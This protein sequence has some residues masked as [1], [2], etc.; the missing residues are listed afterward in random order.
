MTNLVFSKVDVVDEDYRNDSYNYR[1]EYNKVDGIRVFYDDIGSAPGLATYKAIIDGNS[2]G[3]IQL[4][5]Y[6][7]RSGSSLGLENI[8]VKPEYRKLGYAK[9]MYEQAI[10]EFELELMS[11]SYHRVKKPSQIKYWNDIGFNHI[12]LIPGQMGSDK[13]LCNLMT[14]YSDTDTLGCFEL[15]FAGVKRCMGHSQRITK[16]IANKYGCYVTRE[17]FKYAGE[18]LHTVLSNH[19]RVAA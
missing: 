18:L 8:Y 11:I 17:D 14:K 4:Q 9:L 7:S 15:T 2:V 16:K 10:D 19:F 1:V 13:G 6:S 3:F 5:S 12:K